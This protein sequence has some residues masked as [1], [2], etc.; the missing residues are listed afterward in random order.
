M[1]HVLSL[2]DKDEQKNKTL[3]V[4]NNFMTLNE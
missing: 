1:E 4:Q 3:S 2:L